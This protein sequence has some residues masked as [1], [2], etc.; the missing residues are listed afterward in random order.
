MHQSIFF[1]LLLNLVLFRRFSVSVTLF[2]EMKVHN[3]C[4]IRKGMSL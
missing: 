3:F 1:I 4:E 2:L